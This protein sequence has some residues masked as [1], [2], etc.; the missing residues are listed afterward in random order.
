MDVKIKSVNKENLNAFIK[1]LLSVDSFIF[2]TTD[3]DKIKS[4]VFFPERDAVKLASVPTSD[5]FDAKFD[6]PVKLSFF[7]GKKV[8]S[9]LS[10][11]NG[12]IEGKIKCEDYED[13]MRATDV[14]FKD[15][16]LK[17]NIPCTDFS[18]SFMEMSDDEISRAFSTE[19]NLFE[20]DL[21]CDAISRIKSLGTLDNSDTF[22]LYKN[23]KGVGV[24]G[25]NYNNILV[26][27]NDDIDESVVLY[28]KYLELLDREDYKV[29]VCDCK[30]IFE[31]ENTDTKLCIA[32]VAV[33]EEDED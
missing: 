3:N 23:N 18:L 22:T 21:K 16:D 19:D 8:I 1:K 27:E 32:T 6:E 33:D 2:M 17:I 10:H 4:S 30:V 5:I 29:Y 15:E 9:Y 13:S 20:F 11:F 31:S 28:K 12:E 7:D 14:L 25:D 24:K 26:K